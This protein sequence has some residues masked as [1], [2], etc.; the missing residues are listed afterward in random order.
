MPKVA[1]VCYSPIILLIIDDLV[2]TYM[3]MSSGYTDSN[4][5]ELTELYNRLKDKG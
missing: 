4:Y 1:N 2:I 3:G 5:T